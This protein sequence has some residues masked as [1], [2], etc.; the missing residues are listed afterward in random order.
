MPN[1]YS[2]KRNDDVTRRRTAEVAAGGVGHWRQ[3]VAETRLDLFECCLQLFLRRVV[4]AQHV[5]GHDGDRLD[6]RT[7]DARRDRQDDDPATRRRRHKL[8]AHHVVSNKKHI[9]GK[10]LVIYFA[11]RN[12]QFLKKMHN[13]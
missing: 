5:V 2:L 8:Q 3:F 7:G 1:T 11:L 6:L 13:R 4:D 12:K 10:R 9:K